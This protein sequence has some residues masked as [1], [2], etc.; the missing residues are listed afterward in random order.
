LNNTLFKARWT[1]R[2]SDVLKT[3][4]HD[5]FEQS[6]A[7]WLRENDRQD[8]YVNSYMNT[9]TNADVTEYVVVLTDRD[10]ALMLKLALSEVW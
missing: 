5:G 6:V 7:E 3:T 9:D 8:A 10:T 4:R 1:F 2:Q